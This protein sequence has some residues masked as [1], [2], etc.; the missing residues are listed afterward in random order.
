M[1]SISG[2]FDIAK[3]LIEEGATINAFN[4]VS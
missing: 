3:F 4:D 1:A 2:D